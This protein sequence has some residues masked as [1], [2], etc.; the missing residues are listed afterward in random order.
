MTKESG[1]LRIT[2][3]SSSEVSSN[4]NKSE[5]LGFF[6]LEVP[7]LAAFLSALFSALACLAAS[8]S[9]LTFQKLSSTCG[10]G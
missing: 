9:Y 1:E 7:V 8:W 3:S 4:L 2:S 5:V 6:F 10:K